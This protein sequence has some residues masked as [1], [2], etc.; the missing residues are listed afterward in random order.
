MENIST[1]TS[2]KNL[3]P[4]DTGNLTIPFNNEI[5]KMF[6]DKLESVITKI[7]IAEKEKIELTKLRDW[8]LPMLMNGQARMN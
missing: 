7:V 1:G 3:S 4:V 8:L 2:Q 5:V 6:C